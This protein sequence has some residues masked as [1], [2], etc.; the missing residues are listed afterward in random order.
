MGG[1]V[2]EPP[3][4][5]PQ[6]LPFPRALVARGARLAPCIYLQSR[7]QN[8]PAAT[9][10][11]RDGRGECLVAK[12]DQ[13]IPCRWVNRQGL[14]PAGSLSEVAGRSVVPKTVF[15]PP[16]APRTPRWR[17]Q[18][19]RAIRSMSAF[20]ATTLKLSNRPSGRPMAFR[21]EMTCARWMGWIVSTAF[22]S[23]TGAPTTRKSKSRRPP[24][25][26]TPL[27][28]TSARG[29]RMKR[30]FGGPVLPREPP[31]TRFQESGPQFAVDL[32]GYADDGVSQGIRLYVRPV[33]VRLSP[34]RS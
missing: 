14:G 17:H 4:K 27:Y 32:N 22:S 21:Q 29:W 25:T 19:D 26:L 18:R 24:P 31:R 30:F 5:T 34:W 2:S 6:A 20:G 10:A 12:H 9:G 1:E 3:A 7:R 33:H 16:R 13:M 23:T 15:E 28:L 11:G 8:P